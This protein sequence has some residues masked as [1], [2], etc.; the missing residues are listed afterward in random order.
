MSKDNNELN[1]NIE[2]NVELIEIYLMDL[3]VDYEMTSEIRSN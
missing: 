3:I 1:R 2:T